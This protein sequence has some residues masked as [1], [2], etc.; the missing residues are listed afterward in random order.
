M[1]KRD[2]LVD[3]VKHLL[4]R[5]RAPKYLHHFGPKMYELWQHVFALFIRNYCQLSY[6]RTTQFLRQLGFCVATKST[7]QRYAAKLRLPFWQS[8]LRQSI[9]KASR[10]G[11]I[12]GSGLERTQASWHYLKR[13][14]QTTVSRP[15]FYLMMLVSKNHKILSLRL[16]SKRSAEIKD[17]KYLYSHNSKQLSTITLDKGFDA[18]WL[19]EFFHKHNVKSIVPV[20]KNGKRGFHRRKLMRQF[21]QKL[22]NTRN[23]S[24]TTFHALKQKFGS[25]ICSHK[26]TSARSDMYCR[27]ILHN[28]FSWAL[29]VLGCSPPSKKR[30]FYKVK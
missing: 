10:I 25:S 24:E 1:K 29:E 6:I 5:V 12:D 30:K 21:P 14:D 15:C 11:A 18:E 28:L 8:I 4:T 19:H 13:I 17:V 27:A 23:C 20:R 7:L 16:R 3:K 9:G 26:I 2:G 22:Y